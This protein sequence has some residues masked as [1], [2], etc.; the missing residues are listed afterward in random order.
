M[1]I[2]C[3]NCGVQL[4][5]EINDIKAR[6]VGNYGQT[7][8][9]TADKIPEYFVKQCKECKLEVMVQEGFTGILPSRIKKE[10]EK[11]CKINLNKIHFDI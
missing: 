11:K 5:I 6:L 7:G 1:E 4:E 9:L 3:E 10:A 2:M 8:N